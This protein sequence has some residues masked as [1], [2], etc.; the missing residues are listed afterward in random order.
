M[1]ET[2]TKRT[3]GSMYKPPTERPEDTKIGLSEYIEDAKVRWQIHLYEWDEFTTDVLVPTAK[4]VYAWTLQ[5][6]DKVKAQMGTDEEVSQEDKTD[7][8]A[9]V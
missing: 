3:Q 2:P 6:I 8:P 9:G 7:P 4:T 1:T 5:G